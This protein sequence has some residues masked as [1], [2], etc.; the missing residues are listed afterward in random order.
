MAGKEEFHCHQ[1]AAK[2]LQKITED[3]CLKCDSPQ[4]GAKAECPDSVRPQLT[5][6]IQGGMTPE[7]LRA[8]LLQELELIKSQ[9]GSAEGE[10]LQ[11]L[12]KKEAG[13]KATIKA[14]QP[15]PTVPGDGTTGEAS[16]R[17]SRGNRH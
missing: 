14:I 2:G 6:E 7:E 13:I 4:K 8:E 1:A 10:R 12:L 17:M 5:E 9:L 11:E 15:E 16:K 3:F